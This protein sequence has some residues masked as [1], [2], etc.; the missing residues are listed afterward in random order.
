MEFDQYST[1]YIFSAIE[2]RF[3]PRKSRFWY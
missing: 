2:S 1:I 3:Q